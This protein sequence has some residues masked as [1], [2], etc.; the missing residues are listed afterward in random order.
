[1]GL[2]HLT[3]GEIARRFNVAQWQARRAVDSLGEDIPRA[4]L[5]RL[6]P[7]GL[8]GLVEAEMRRRGYLA[9]EPEAAHA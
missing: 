6:V 1:M 2:T 7:V 3:I 4:G 5:Y 9:E 8:L